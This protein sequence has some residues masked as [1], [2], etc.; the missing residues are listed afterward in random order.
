MK[1]YVEKIIKDYPSMVRERER[2]KKQIQRYEFLS[3]EE[4]ISAMS[5]SRPDGERVQSSNLSDKTARIAILYEDQL[6]QMNNE[7]LI[8]MIERLQQL[9]QEITLLQ[10][11]IKQLPDGLAELMQAL[12]I[13]EAT[14]DEIEMNFYL[15]RKIISQNRKRAIEY[16]VRSYQIRESQMELFLLS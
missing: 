11:E 15:S 9:D 1:G 5:F 16:L 4:L 6:E 2:L 12:V 14:W 7:I 10:S 8:P 13:E 3:A